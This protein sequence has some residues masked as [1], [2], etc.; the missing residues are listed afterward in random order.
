MA[1]GFTLASVGSGRAR[2]ANAPSEPSTQY[3]AGDALIFTYGQAYR[4]AAASVVRGILS[5]MRPDDSE[6]EMATPLLS[7]TKQQIVDY[8]PV[9]D[10]DKLYK[11]FLTGV[12]AP[13]ILDVAANANSTT[14]LVLVTAAGSSSDYLGGTVFSNGEQRNIIT[15]AVNGGVHTFTVDKAFTRAIT[16]GDKVRAVP[17][18]KGTR[19]VKLSAS[20][21][22]QGISPAI[23]D[24]S[25]GY[26]SIAG[27][28]LSGDYPFAI[29]WFELD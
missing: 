6:F 10:T 28:D 11:T 2:L 29:V 1:G 26:V 3:K 16:T 7:T 8:E 24:K 17:F 27:V 21:A 5:G 15:D 4:A 12:D 14:N 20:D 19:H 9:D 13:P 23:A 18:A 25:G 22:A